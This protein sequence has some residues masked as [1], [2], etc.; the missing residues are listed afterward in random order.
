MN[1]D[2]NKLPDDYEFFDSETKKALKNEYNSFYYPSASDVFLFY[3]QT[4]CEAIEK[5]SKRLLEIFEKQKL[6]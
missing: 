3:N 2:Y 5:Q 6:I 4:I 1:R